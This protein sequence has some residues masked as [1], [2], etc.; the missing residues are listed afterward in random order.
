MQ[1]KANGKKKKKYREEK[2][3]GRWSLLRCPDRE[4][5]GRKFGDFF[6]AVDQPWP[7]SGQPKEAV[8]G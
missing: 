5:N 4:D 2:G 3:A 8:L 7:I 6:R 1:S